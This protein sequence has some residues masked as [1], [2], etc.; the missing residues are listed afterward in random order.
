MKIFFFFKKA[1]KILNSFCLNF[2]LKNS[3]IFFLFS[4]IIDLNLQYL[5]L[6]QTKNYLNNLKSEFIYSFYSFSNIELKKKKKSFSILQN[7]YFSN[8]LKNYNLILPISNFFEYNGS[9]LNFE[10]RLRKKLKVYSF[11]NL[12]LKSNS[13][14]FKYLNIVVN[15]SLNFLNFNF[16]LLKFFY[17]FLL[18]DYDQFINNN[19][20]ILNSVS[21]RSNYYFSLFFDNYKIFDYLINV[22]KFKNLYKT[23]FSLNKASIYLN[24]YLSTYVL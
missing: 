5:N 4:N 9:F 17:S 13:E 1:Y 6:N 16:K 2:L 23:S 10:G 24:T 19:I 14:I 11:N 7:S 12:K 15:M 21:I 20:I 18:K 8:N 22:Y 3:D